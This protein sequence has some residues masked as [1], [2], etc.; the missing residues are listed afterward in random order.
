MQ[1]LHR[2]SLRCTPAETAAGLD[3]E[4]RKLPAYVVLDAGRT[5]HGRIYLEVEGPA[6]SILDIGW[7]ERLHTSSRRPYPYP[8]SLYP[9]WNQVDS[10]VLDGR[11]RSIH[12]IDARAGR[13]ILIAVWGEGPVRLSQIQALEER[14]PIEQVGEFHSSNPLLD[15]IWQVGVDTLRPNMT[16]AF[17]DTPW[18]ERGQ[19]WGDVHA[20]NRIARVA[21]QDQRLL[22]RSL[23]YMADAL[24]R[25]EAPGLVPNN[26]GLR[27]LDYSML[28]VQD[29]AGYL[30]VTGDKNLATEL[31]PRLSQLMKNLE[32]AE[33]DRSGLL[34]LP[35]GPWSETAYI[36]VA[37]RLSRSGQSAALNSIYYETLKQ[38]AWVADFTGR[39]TAARRWTNKSEKIRSA[40]NNLLYRPEDHRYLASLSETGYS[41]PTVH[42]QAWPLAFDIIPEDQRIQA[43]KSLLEM[44]PPDPAKSTF[45]TY[46]MLWILEAL[47]NAGFFQQAVALI[48]DYYG[49][50]LQS[51]AQTWW[52]GFH[53]GEYPETSISHG[54]SGAPT[55]FLT[56]FILGARSDDLDRWV[57]RPSFSAV[58]R[59]AGRLPLASGVLEVE[60]QNPGCGESNLTISAPLQTRGEV[61]FP[62]SWQNLELLLDGES[63]LGLEPTIQFNGFQDL[64]GTHIFLEGGAHAFSARYLCIP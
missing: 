42:S 5:I 27:M 19:W 13:Y 21:F 14:Y 15:R 12:T 59:A 44:I 58:G 40:I 20:E 33:N 36:D 10:W 55:W 18:R 48:E 51:G 17:T 26:Q 52:E 24:Q 3:L 2:I 29:L 45:G 25:S 61:V 7:D 64:Q 56:N 31:F 47:G 54:W 39:S 37:A 11:M 28:W 32:K 34:D 9:Q 53:A 8:G 62:N 16:D 43:T 35:E 57:V 41:N 49:Y 46:G 50:I 38:A 1:N 30:K 4:F 63:I 23:I 6:G 60:W 22:R